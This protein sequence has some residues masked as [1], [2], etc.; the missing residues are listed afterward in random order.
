M[1]VY[2]IQFSDKQ[3]RHTYLINAS[4][5]HTAIGRAMKGHSLPEKITILVE[6]VARKTTWQ[7]LQKAQ[8]PPQAT[9]NG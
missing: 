5:P 7:E 9:N 3:K 1:N 8:E 2:R 6:L 4:A